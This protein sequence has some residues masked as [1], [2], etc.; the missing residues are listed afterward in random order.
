M[1]KVLLCNVVIVARFPQN[2]LNILPCKNTFG[3]WVYRHHHFNT[4]YTQT[5]ARHKSVPLN[6]DLGNLL[7][8][9]ISTIL[10]HSLFLLLSLPLSVSPAVSRSI[11]SSFSLHKSLC[12]LCSPRAQ[13]M[14][15][16]NF[17]VKQFKVLRLMSSSVN[18]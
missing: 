12:V 13:Q 8:I 5:F 11:S 10:P 3:T 18:L 1:L 4:H 9:S 6:C 7:S 15:D 17:N 14:H 16:R 2:L